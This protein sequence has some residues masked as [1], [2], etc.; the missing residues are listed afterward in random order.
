MPARPA[1][2]NPIAARI[3]ISVAEDSA[4]LH[5]SSLLHAAREHLPNVEFYGFAGPRM[6]AAGAASLG[7]LTAHAAM[8][9]GI[10]KVAGRGWRA[11]QLAKK[12]WREN[13]PDL[14]LLMD[15]TALHLPMA[16]AAKKFGLP[17]LY[18]IAPQTWASRP[19]RN[20]K[21]A[22]NVQQVA[23][24]LPFEEP[25]FRKAGVNATY[26]GHPLIELLERTPINAALQQQLK[27]AAFD[28]PLVALLPGSRAGVIARMLPLQLRVIEHI[29]WPVRVAVSCVSHRRVEQIRQITSAHR[30]YP[31]IVVGDNAALLT[32]ARAA[33]VASGTA[34]LEAAFYRTPMVVMYDAGPL[35]RV[36]YQLG[37]RR[38]LKTRRLSL[39][40]IL[41]DQDAVPEF[42]PFVPD[43]EPV[44]N[45]LAPLLA[46]IDAAQEMAR[47]LDQVIDPL[48]GSRASE[49]VCDLIA[50]LLSGSSPTR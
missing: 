1:N 32:A 44:A 22:R 18:Y 25:F 48:R 34:T 14:V 42:M 16:A 9:G 33:L 7:D 2:A 45:A 28:A 17:V 5:A 4:D 11:L 30:I 39:V 50:G 15:S 3:F 37:G 46:H 23:C 13:R 43:V 21:L 12:S 24:I 47:R 49:R 20:G 29:R 6:Q 10:L 26:V 19:G 31:H 8:L 36:G 27:G 40:N 38:L 41:A 35:F